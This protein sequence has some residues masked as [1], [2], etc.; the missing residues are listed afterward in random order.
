MGWM[1]FATCGGGQISGIDVGGRAGASSAPVGVTVSGNVSVPGQAGFLLRY[2]SSDGYRNSYYSPWVVRARG[3]SFGL[4]M[5][6][7]DAFVVNDADVWAML[8]ARGYS[9]WFKVVADGGGVAQFTLEVRSQNRS[10]VLGQ[11]SRRRVRVGT[12]NHSNNPHNHGLDGYV[13]T[14]THVKRFA[15]PIMFDEIYDDGANLRWYATGWPANRRLR[16]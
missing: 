16:D 5:L 7:S 13:D 9:V 2:T 10:G 6:R 3:T 15:V 12:W 11:V 4:T 1:K 14:V 8:D